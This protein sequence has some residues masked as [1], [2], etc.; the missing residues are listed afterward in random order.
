MNCDDSGPGSLRDVIAHAL[1]GDHVEI[2]ADIGCDA[3]ALTSGPIVIANDA[4][5]QPFMQLNIDGP[6]R[7]AFAIDGGGLDRVFVQDAGF[8]AALQLYG[9]KV[10][11][12]ASDTSGGC[13]Y[14]AGAVVLDDV[15]V[16]D[17]VAGI[18]S[19]DT[20]LGNPAV[21]GGGIY[22]VQTAY[23]FNSTLTRN[24]VYGGAADAYGGGAFSPGTIGAINSTISENTIDSIG[25]AAYGGGLA[26]GDHHPGQSVALTLIASSVSSNTSHSSCSFCGSRGGGAWAYASAQ[27]LDGDFSGNVASSSYGYGTGGGLYF[28]TGYY[29]ASSTT[30]VIGTHFHCNSA[31]TGGG[32]AAIGTLAVSRAI[33]DCNTATSDGGAIALLGDSVTLTDSSLLANVAIGRG[34]GIF[35]F[36]YG[37]TAITNSTISGNVAGNGG[38]LGN[39]YGSLHIANSTIADN[40]AFEHGGGV[41]FRYAYYEFEARS[42]IIAGNTGNQVPED[43]W[44]PGMTVS[45]SHDLITAADGVEVPADTLSADPMLAAPAPNGGPTLT[46][47]LGEGSPAIDAGSNDA[48]LDFDQRGEG[49]VRV[50]GAAADIGAF[51]VQPSLPSDVIF[52]NGFEL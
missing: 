51:E 19:G 39:T 24:H 45:G 49:F 18:V 14:A 17:C 41:F 33:F 23:L 11:S 6:G 22:A 31:D 28:D 40:V 7:D 13:I 50:F 2:P 3:I 25:G 32:I 16:S 52:A 37:D 1:S 20:T 35:Q 44:P 12:G 34:G 10:R 5:G 43:L 4:A 27:L 15:E 21:R 48:G 8:Y 29:A 47:A 46:Q 36:G 26:A 30:S 38:A 9:L 42:S